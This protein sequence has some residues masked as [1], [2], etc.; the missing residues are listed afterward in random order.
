MRL[1]HEDS[2]DEIDRPVAI[3]LMQYA[4]DRGVNYVD[5]AYAYHGGNS[6]LVVGEAL[7]NGYRER[8]YLATKMPVWEVESYTDF[9]RLLDEQLAKLG[10][11]YLDFYLLHALRGPRWDKVRDL[12]V[13]DWVRRPLSDG[14]IR[15]LGFSFHDSYDRFVEI[16]AEYDWEFCQVQYNIL[17]EDVQAGT[18]GVTY[19]AENGVALV[20]MEPLYGGSLAQPPDVVR[21][22]LEADGSSHSIVDLALRWL[23][24]KP[25]IGVVLSGMNTLEQ[26]QQNLLSAERSGVGSLSPDERELI[27]RIQDAYRTLSPVPCTKCRYCM[28]CPNGVDIPRNFEMYNQAMLHE[29]GRTVNRINYAHMTEAER[30][31]ACIAC[32]ECEE[33]CPQGIEISA[34]MPKV[35]ELLREQ[36]G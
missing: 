35:D 13:L 19:A 4:F 24:D 21:A 8:V 32:R 26:V 22:V 10:V 17:C 2:E 18:R 15:H 1:P 7:A 33:Q 28:P 6:E 20:I 30:A 14:R 9:D 29:P 5:T 11:D 12:G 25:E 36:G 31:A 23:W 27:G 3:E 34:W 16:L